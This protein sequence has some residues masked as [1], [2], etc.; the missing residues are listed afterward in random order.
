MNSIVMAGISPHPPLIIPEIGRGEI[1]KVE[2]T[3]EAMKTLAKEV[4]EA[5]PETIVIITPHGPVFKNAVSFLGGAKLKGDMSRFGVPQVEMEVTN[6][7]GLMTSILAEVRKM[8]LPAFIMDEEESKKYDASQ[9]L[10][11]GSLVPIYYLKEAGAN[12]LYII[13]TIGL[14]SHADLFSLG[15]A[16]QKAT[17]DRKRKVAVIASG[18]LSHCLIPGAPA[19]YHEAGKEFDQKLTNLIKEYRVEEIMNLDKG[20]VNNAAE[21]GLK[22]IIMCLG[23][24]D[25]YKVQPEISSYEGPFGVGY[26]VALFRI[27]EFEKKREIHG[28]DDQEEKKKVTKEREE[29]SILVRLARET[30]ESYVNEGELPQLPEPL[31]QE[32]QDKGGVFVSLKKKG[33]LRGCIGTIEPV[34]ENLAQEIVRNTLS[35]ALSDPRFPPVSEEELPY[36]KYSVDVLM[37]PE[38]V[39]DIQE[40]D[41]HKYGVIVESSHKRGLLLPNLEGVDTVEEQLSIAR[42][43]AGIE[44]GE[45]AKI[46]RFE[47][48]RY[49]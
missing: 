37:P 24:L 12:T 48:R 10:D 39:E 17:F 28:K 11:H 38:P 34:K 5:E 47:V 2:K 9:E 41:P 18:D 46:Y 43:K 23:S 27:L 49:H 32:L 15:K 19:G 33:M 30:L 14:L 31:P 21:C 22:P 13:I 7:E 4:K 8:N 42:Q 25:G 3:V 36:L 35:A 45:E 29:E 20:L 44:P 26:L 1:K 6:D 40:L 16:I